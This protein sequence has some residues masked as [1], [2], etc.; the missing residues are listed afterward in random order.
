[1]TASC[2]DL[3]KSK[4]N[5]RFFNG[6]GNDFGECSAKNSKQKSKT[7]SLHCMTDQCCVA[8]IFFF[9]FFNRS[10]CSNRWNVSAY[11][12]KLRDP[13]HFVYIS[14]IMRLMVLTLD[15]NHS[16]V[17]CL[18]LFFFF[19]FFLSLS[20]QHN[21]AN[22]FNT[23]HHQWTKGNSILFA[24][25]SKQHEVN[26]FLAKPSKIQHDKNVVIYTVLS[27]TAQHTVSSCRVYKWCKVHTCSRSFVCHNTKYNFIIIVYLKENKRMINAEV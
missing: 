23:P 13:V 14:R 17:D 27:L 6:N 11:N 18:F 3:L 20:V 2:S 8:F 4:A 7:N 16:A 26:Y 19:P 24:N 15:Y 25:N 21:P 1:M 22:F 12:L 10:V 5:Q 9:F